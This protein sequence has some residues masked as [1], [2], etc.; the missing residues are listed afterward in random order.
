MTPR[1]LL[2]SDENLESVEN[3]PRVFDPVTAGSTFC[4][5]FACEL[6]TVRGVDYIFNIPVRFPVWRVRDIVSCG[7][8]YNTLLA[9]IHEAFPWNF[10]RDIILLVSGDQV[11]ILNFWLQF[12]YRSLC[13]NPHLLVSETFGIDFPGGFCRVCLVSLS[14]PRDGRLSL[15]RESKFAA[16]GRSQLQQYRPNSEL[17]LESAWVPI[18][19]L[20]LHATD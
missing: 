20:R 7:Y 12:A 6:D 13:S 11:R 8:L 9:D 5:G 16:V 1:I 15:P 18:G 2:V 3:T 17:K 4:K 10:D 14:R 19:E